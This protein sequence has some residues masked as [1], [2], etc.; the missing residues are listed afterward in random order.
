[1]S[2]FSIVS[3][4]EQE[5]KCTLS[6][7][8]PVYNEADNIKALIEATTASL[9]GLGVT[10]EIILVDDGSNDSTWEII[11]EVARHPHVK[12]ISLS[13]N[14]GPQKAMFAGL[15]YCRGD[16][17]VT[18]DGDLQHPPEKIADLVNAWRQ[19]Y[20]VVETIRV[21]SRDVSFLKR[22][23]SRLFYRVFSF[24]SG[25]P[26]EAGTSDFRLID[27]QVVT[28]IINMRDPDIFLK[29][30]THWVGFKRTTV[31]YQAAERRSGST[32]WTWHKLI[33]YSIASLI[34]FSLVPLRMGI[35]LGFATSFLAF[36]ELVYIFYRYFQGIDVPGWAST[37]TV[38]S[39]M[40]GM[41]FILIGIIGSYL[42][43]TVEMLKNRPRFL[44]SE[45]CGF[46]GEQN[47]SPTSQ[48]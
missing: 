37:L 10:Y 14:F 12:G 29:G 16:A 30:I 36:L 34:S 45:L 7:V 23:T 3:G 26:M 38:I 6:V 33:R 15:H 32:K 22:L 41:L 1:V 2:E 13:R 24:L 35:W 31:T 40:F 27:R 44:V 39:F 43:S 9:Q 42:G 28:T 25:L 19:G 20:K 8:V 4:E 17:V 46:P 5:R 11:K 18:M 21:D 48:E 47:S